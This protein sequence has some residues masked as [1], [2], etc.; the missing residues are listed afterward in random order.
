[1]D[2]GRVRMEGAV[3]G[4]VDKRRLGRKGVAAPVQDPEQGARWRVAALSVP[5]PPPDP[6]EPPVP[7]PL[8]GGSCRRPIFCLLPFGIRFILWGGKKLGLLKDGRGLPLY[9]ACSSPRPGTAGTWVHLHK[10]PSLCCIPDSPSGPQP[11][12]N[13]LFSSSLQRGPFVVVIFFFL[14]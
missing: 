13:L 4:E 12:P 9:R 14:I 5:P 1:M 6:E 3:S 2:D 8:A 11:S 7:S 10:A